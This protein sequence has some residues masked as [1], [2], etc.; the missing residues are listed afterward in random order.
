M[1][2]P[3]KLA[4]VVLFTRQVP[5][6]RDWYVT[7]LDGRVVHQNPAA[8]FIT[9]DDEHHRIAV[10]DPGAA[11]RMAHAL[12]GKSDGLVGAGGAA[13]VEW[14]AGQPGDAAP[15]G[16]AHIAFTYDSL[17]DLL[18]TYERLK[19][20][21]ILPTV[22]INHGTTT[23]MYF[24]DPDGNQIELQVDNFA[25]AAEG[26]EFMESQSFMN[27]PV[28]VAFDADELIQKLRSGVPAR[29]LMAPSW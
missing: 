2:S 28:G 21:A 14:T 4:H 17:E 6:M 20:E 10:T 23:S 12:F 22:T 11:A 5:R 15:H 7:V 29:D 3:T 27:N 13:S 18:G 25:S 16:L 19:A 1:A 9:Y 24:A 26:T 8:A